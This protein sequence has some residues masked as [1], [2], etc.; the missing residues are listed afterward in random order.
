MTFPY[1]FC[2]HLNFQRREVS[3]HWILLPNHLKVRYMYSITRYQATFQHSCPASLPR[4]LCYPKAEPREQVRVLPS[5]S[6]QEAAVSPAKHLAKRTL[7]AC[8]E[9]SKG[10]SP[11]LLLQIFLSVFTLTFYSRPGMYFWRVSP[12]FLPSA[13]FDAL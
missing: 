11:A 6:Y 8:W 7:S 12:S 1:L 2:V 5:V 10:K 4:P 9:S 13:S 3:F